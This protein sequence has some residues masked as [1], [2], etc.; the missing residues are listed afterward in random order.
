MSARHEYHPEETRKKISHP[1]IDGDG[2]WIEYTP[3]FAE[4]MRKVV[5]DKGADGFLASQRRIPDALSLTIER[6]QGARRRD[7]GLLGPAIDQHARPRHR[8]DAAHAV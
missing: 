7:G 1:V 5:G 3:V 6:A 4:R 2:H 8:D